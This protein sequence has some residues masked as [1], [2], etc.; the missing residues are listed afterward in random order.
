MGET[1][2]STGFSRASSSDDLMAKIMAC[3]PILADISRADLLL[4]RFVNQ[5]QVKMVGQARPNSILPLYT[6]SL[7]GQRFSIRELPPIYMQINNP[8]YRPKPHAAVL[9]GTP[10]VREVHPVRSQQDGQ[11]I[12]ALGIETNV[13]AYER[14]RRRSRAFQRALGQLQRTAL[15]GEIR[16][17]EALSPFGEH[18]GVYFVDTQHRILYVNGIA[19]NFFRRLGY[20]GKLVSRRLDSLATADDELVERTLKTQ[21]CWEQESDEQGGLAWIRKTL[22]VRDRKDW[23]YY[24]PVARWMRRQPGDSYPVGV[25][26]MIHDDTETR[27]QAQELKVQLAMIQEVHHRVKN[28][29]QTIASLLRLQSRRVQESEMRT[30]LLES[31]NRILSIAVVHEFLSKGG[32]S[33]INVKEVGRRIIGQMRESLLDPSKTI[34]LALE[35]PSIY[36]PAR[37]ATACALI[38]NELLQNAVEHGYAHKDQGQIKL[39]L[40]DEGDIVQIRVRDDGEGLPPTFSLAQTESLGLRIVQALVQDDL[41]GEFALTSADSQTI[42]A[43]SFAKQVAESGRI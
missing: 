13:L 15:R 3:L 37:Q 18:D 23:L 16:G 30:I 11:I 10:I 41:H 14:H 8:F 1:K 35:G 24:N 17:A 9:H 28:N 5:D 20:M 34:E 38:I 36:L 33:V 22:P 40:I 4:Y 26:V 6:E 39:T 19:T 43:V 7:E 25:M 27:R 29:L 31:I 32:G 42:A 2:V 12:G 21:R